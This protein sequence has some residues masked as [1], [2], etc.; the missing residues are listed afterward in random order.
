MSM[1]VS[2]NYRDCR[3][4][5][6]ERLQEGK[7]STKA[8]ASFFFGS[9]YNTLGFPFSSF[10]IWYNPFGLA[11]DFSLLIYSSFGVRKSLMLQ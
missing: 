2:G 4:E 3:N 6:W 11:P 8:A 5:F 1:Q 7:D 9:S 10:P